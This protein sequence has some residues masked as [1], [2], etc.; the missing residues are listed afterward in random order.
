MQRII[1]LSL[2]AGILVAGCARQPEIPPKNIELTANDQMKYD[3][4]SFEV[5]AQQP[6]SVTLK[7]IGVQPKAA[8]GHNFVVLAKNTEID[9]FLDA[10]RDDA[11]NEYIAAPQAFHVLAKTKLLGPGES[12]TV[13]FT[14]PSVPGDYVYLCTFPGHYVSGMKGVMTVTP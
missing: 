8:M 5:K 2:V 14:A 7:N 4:A 13:T 12:D 9:K 3:L 6:V 1:L 10:G 11:A